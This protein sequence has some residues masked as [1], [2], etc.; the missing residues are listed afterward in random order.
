MTVGADSAVMTEQGT[1]LARDLNSAM[2]VNGL[3]NSASAGFIDYRK[4]KAV[5]LETLGG[6]EL[7]CTPDTVVCSSQGWRRVDEAEDV[8]LV[9]YP[10]RPCNTEAN[11]RAKLASGEVACLP[12]GVLAAY[13]DWH[14]KAEGVVGTGFAI[15][16]DDFEVAKAAQ[17]GL[18]SAG[19]PCR[20]RLDVLTLEQPWASR[21][22]EIIGIRNTSIR[23]HVELGKLMGEPNIAASVCRRVYELLHKQ[24]LEKDRVQDVRVARVQELGSFA[25]NYELTHADAVE[26][27]ELLRQLPARDGFIRAMLVNI[28]VANAASR[29][30]VP[31]RRVKKLG[32]TEMVRITG[33]DYF[34][35]G[36]AIKAN[37]KHETQNDRR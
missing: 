19:I 11:Y 28:L 23:A 21:Y 32:R 17:Q 29:E 34:A 14:N 37:Q 7:V 22:S 27:A 31:V 3:V 8:L 4:T 1:Y 5:V 9:A 20:R 26:M 25:Q 10:N 13:V 6:Y 2:M 30:I 18:L 24:G 36:F 33:N 15:R 35:N 12:D 16:L